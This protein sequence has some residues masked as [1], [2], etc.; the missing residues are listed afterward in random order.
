LEDE[1]L[2]GMGKVIVVVLAVYFV[3][4]IEDLA[5]RGN[6]GLVFQANT[7]AVLFWGEMGLGVLL[8][9]ILMWSER[10]R[11]NRHALFFA[12]LLTVIGFVV[13]RLNVA[14][15]GM[16]RSTGESYFPSAMELGITL[17]LVAAGFVA[18]G[19]AVKY[20]DLFPKQEMEHARPPAQLPV[21][22]LRGMPTANGW[23]LAG[24][25][26]LLAAGLGLVVIATEGE[27]ASPADD[28]AVVTPAPVD[29]GELTVPEDYTW[30]GNEASPGNVTFSHESHMGYLEEGVPPCA[31]CHT[32]GF[33][34]VA[35]GRAIS[36][37]VTMERMRGGALCGAC[38]DG[39]RAFGL[40][41]EGDCSSCHE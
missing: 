2:Q 20:L 27:A 32:D 29:L 1:L 22:G 9:M 35:K 17:A 6:L 3:W 25:W 39:E 28:G 26:V 31:S 38:H 12:A 8:P 13:N 11:H 24:L 15:T 40:T 7:E 19:L 34:L 33:S 21:L 18:F 14:L 36:G 41:E 16:A 23:G 37:A 30:E 10:M 5:G 4:K